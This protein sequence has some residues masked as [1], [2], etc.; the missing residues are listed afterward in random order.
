MS[1]SNRAGIGC[2]GACGGWSRRPQGTCRRRRASSR[3]CA[4]AVRA[5]HRT[6]RQCRERD[7]RRSTISSSSSMGRPVRIAH[8]VKLVGL[9]KLAEKTRHVAGDVRIVQSELALI[10]VADE[11]AGKRVRVDEPGPAYT[12]P[13]QSRRSN[14]LLIQNGCARAAGLL[15]SPLLFLELCAR[16]APAAADLLD[17]NTEITGIVAFGKRRNQV[18]W[19]WRGRV[20]RSSKWG[21]LRRVCP[22]SL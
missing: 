22:G 14:R 3:R 19:Q 10:A 17:F 21:W 13:K 7:R 12:P 6:R 20:R 15:L 2:G 11:P 1:S 4:C 16:K 8:A 5:R 18:C 9:G